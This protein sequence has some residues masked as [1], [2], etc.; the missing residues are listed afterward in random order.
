MGHPWR[1]EVAVQLDGQVAIIWGFGLADPRGVALI[2]SHSVIAGGD[3]A[4]G[5]TYF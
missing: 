2:W 3:I 1:V 4:I 5:R